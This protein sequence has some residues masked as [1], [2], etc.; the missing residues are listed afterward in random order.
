MSVHGR[1]RRLEAVEAKVKV[2]S[3]LVTFLCLCALGRLSDRLVPVIAIEVRDRRFD[4]LANES[5]E[6]LHERA[7]PGGSWRGH[8]KPIFGEV[9]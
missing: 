3:G 6:A 1:L 5:L 2:E 8:P 9:Q 7:N 4:R